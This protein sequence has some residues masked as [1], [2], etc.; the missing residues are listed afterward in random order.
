MTAIGP[1]T[2]GPSLFHLAHRREAVPDAGVDRHRELLVL[3]PEDLHAYDPASVRAV[4]DALPAGD[5]PL[6]LDDARCPLAYALRLAGESKRPVWMRRAAPGESIILPAP[7]FQALRPAA[8]RPLYVGGI[9]AGMREARHPFSREALIRVARGRL[10]TGDFGDYGENRLRLLLRIISGR[11]DEID[12][13]DAACPPRVAQALADGKGKPV[14]LWL[15][16]GS[17]TLL[18]R[19]VLDDVLPLTPG[20][21]AALHTVQQAFEGIRH[22]TQTEAAFEP[23]AALRSG[24]LTARELGDHSLAQAW[25]LAALVPADLPR[26]HVLDAHCPQGFVTLLADV[27]QQPVHWQGEDHPPDPQAQARLPPGL[28][29]RDTDVQAALRAAIRAGPQAHAALS[30]H[31]V[32]AG[33]LLREDLGD[34]SAS[35]LH[36]L[37]AALDPRLRA[38]HL[39]ADDCPPSFAQALADA[40]ARPAV[41]GPLVHLPHFVSPVP[42]PNPAAD[43]HDFFRIDRIERARRNSSGLL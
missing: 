12:I 29:R 36:A 14:R 43:S 22:D 35:R 3:R 13:T 41:H 31:Y 33:R 23:D 11:V 15:G 28:S 10:E 18:P 17:L 24:R 27:L 4:C 7:L 32:R 19:E 42:R 39:L 38:V 40:A 16:G 1:I 5:G 26:V 30:R 2:S 21:R 20:E 6:L 9:V 25:V 37:L 34:F 8:H